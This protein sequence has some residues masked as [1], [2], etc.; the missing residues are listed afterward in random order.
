MREKRYITLITYSYSGSI[1]LVITAISTLLCLY[2]KLYF[3]I[4]KYIYRKKKPVYKMQSSPHRSGHPLW[5]LGQ[6]P[7]HKGNYCIPPL[8]TCERIWYGLDKKWVP[9]PH[10]FPMWLDWHDGIAGLQ[11]ETRSG[12]EWWVTKSMVWKKLPP[13]PAPLYISLCFLF[14]ILWAAFLHHAPLPCHSALE[15]VNDGLKPLLLSCVGVGYFS[16]WQKG[17]RQIAVSEKWDHCCYC[18]KVCGSEA[19]GNGSWEEFG[20][21]WKYCLEKLP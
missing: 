14:T 21:V 16:Y 15:P 19:F 3:V 2:Y 13:S 5:V 18:I 1:L 17:L 10:V 20:K 6:I 9:M 4:A 7:V 8:L 11:L 12:Q